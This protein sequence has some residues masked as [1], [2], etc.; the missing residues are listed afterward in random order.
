M[1]VSLEEVRRV[2]ALANLELE[3]SAEERLRGHLEEILGYVGQLDEVNT[4]GVA[5]AGGAVEAAEGMRA[6]RAAPSL[7][8]GAAL[9]NAPESG[10]GHFKVPRILP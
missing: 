1:K 4:E 3:A 10:Q 9:A 8:T 5:P 2:A 7:D 6:D